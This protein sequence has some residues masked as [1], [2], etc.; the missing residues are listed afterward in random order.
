MARPIQSLIAAAQHHPPEVP[1]FPCIDPVETAADKL[2][3]LAWRV[4]ARQRGAVGDDATIIRHLHDLAA[5]KSA[6]EG[7]PAFTTLVLQA[8]AADAGRGGEA[9][10]SSDPA[11]Q[12]TGMIERLRSDTLWAVEYDDFVRQVS[13]AR[14][15]EWIGFEQALAAVVALVDMLGAA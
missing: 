3:A 13:F 14:P 10:A 7:A 6:V 2:S 15:D 1:A 11:T 12:W 9:T 4:L 5:L 8:A